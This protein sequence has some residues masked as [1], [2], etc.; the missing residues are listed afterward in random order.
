MKY[1]CSLLLVVI[2]FSCRDGSNSI[3]GKVASRP[4]LD[5][6]SNIVRPE[7]QNPYE[8]VDVS[9]MDMS[10]L[11]DDYPILKMD[12][13]TNK[14]PVARVIYSRPQMQG[15]KIFG[16]LV[17]YGEP[18]RLGA[19]EAT[20][21]QLFQAVTIDGKM[22]PAGRYVLYCIPQSDKW[23]IVFNSNFDCWGLKQD[24]AK[25]LYKFTIPVT[26]KDQAI[27]YYTMVFNKTDRG[28]DLVMAWD[29]IEARLPFQYNDK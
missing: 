7:G 18:W 16:S 21:L 17:K 25:D 23:T 9:P 8:P 6:D 28:A 14:P 2:F 13:K 15:R 27:E 10:Y 26:E 24:P 4:Y 5:K 29:N 19:N 22:I 11:P 12:N 20:E 3:P 1:L